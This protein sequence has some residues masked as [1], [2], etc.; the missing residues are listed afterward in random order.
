MRIPRRARISRGAAGA[1]AATIAAAALILTNPLAAR[2]D[3]ST[4][5]PT[6]ITTTS[7]STGSGQSAANLAVQDLSGTTDTWSKYVEF[8]GQYSGYLTYAVPT[9][10]AP[11]SIT[12]IQ[13]KV[14][15]R[16]PATS[17]QTWTFKLYDWSSSSWVSVG[18]N[19]SAPDWGAW[20]LLTFNAS[21]TLSN[22][23]SSGSAMR[24]QLIA[25]NASDS[26][27]IDYAAIVLSTS[28]SADTTAPS[29]PANL[30]V[31][32][33][34]S[35]SVSL[36]WSAS[37]DNV[38]VTGYEVFQGS[39][40]TPVA[41]VTTTSA[42]VTGLAA[43]TTYSFTVKA[44][45]AA[46]NRS[47]ASASVS[48]TTA[49]SGGLPAPVTCS[50]CWHPP[51]QTSWNWVI[52]VV[53]TAPYRNVSMYDIDGFNATAADVTSL[54]NAGKKVVC[55]ISAGTYEDWRPDA[56]QFPASILGSNVQG[57]QGERW[58]DVR[59]VQQANSALAAIMNARLDM[60][61]NKGFDAVE[62]DNVD[63][64]TNSPGFPLT[65]SDQAYY[66]V[67][68][69]NGARSRGMSAVMKNDIDQI[70]SLLPYFDMA[71]NEEC[72]ANNECGAY[73]QFVQAGKP[74]FNAEYGSSTSFCSADNAANYNGV[75]FAL[76]LNDSIF[77]P[78]R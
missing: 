3:T 39:G 36:S 31:T 38:G 43:S 2:A 77:Q 49:S 27:D 16:G 6:A 17:T 28:S 9:T 62:F 25:N 72:N 1:A 55:Y 32:G 50:G 19:A 22:F 14:N 51:L 70:S 78:C 57:W 74:V 12:G 20:T 18:T 59:N 11:S 58:L 29:V 47:A 66:N 34:T 44:R 76:D 35:S 40:T 64:Y 23:V 13:V 15:Y 21:G 69:A 42:T 48:A 60:C 52:S 75:R 8:S 67:F 53:P 71:L 33:T 45:D 26:A 10:I 5:T 4:V 68:L 7:G 37:T 30:A 61:K 46:G 56:S 63:G 65:A 24:L 73:S 54:H 41:T